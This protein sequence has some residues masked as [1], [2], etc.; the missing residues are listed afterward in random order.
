MKKKLRILCAITLMLFLMGCKKE[1]YYTL[2]TKTKEYIAFFGK[3]S[4]WKYQ[5][6]GTSDTIRWEAVN[7]S[8]AI[9]DYESSKGDYFYAY[10]GNLAESPELRYQT[11]AKKENDITSSGWGE[12]LSTDLTIIGDGNLPLEDSLVVNG[13]MYNKVLHLTPNVTFSYKDVWIAPNVG[14]IKAKDNRSDKV[15]L[16]KSYKIEKL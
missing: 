5:I 15:Y 1:P 2:K 13:I 9:M 11:Y 8:L 10:G 6:E 12:I 14:I 3:G 16:L 7:C 4:W